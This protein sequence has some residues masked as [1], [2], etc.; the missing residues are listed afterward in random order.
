M[1]SDLFGSLGGLMKG[2]SGIMPQDD[3]KTQL[4]KLQSEVSDL[5]K[6]ENDLYAEIGRAAME[7]YGAE[8]FGETA[9]RLQLVQTDLAAARQKLSEAQAA[10][11]ERKRAEE[12][13]AAERRRA[14]L[15]AREERTCPKCGSENPEGTKFCQE[16][17][18]R[19]GQKNVCTSCG[20]ANALGVKFCQECGTRLQSEAAPAAC[21]DCGQE[22]PPGT[23][24]CGGCGT[25]LS[26]EN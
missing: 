10:E 23:R 25:K 12:A 21:P 20:T 7:Q 22:N 2:L 6:Q 14:E 5:Q 13:A 15:A 11:E 18:T 16:C 4:F 24:F 17:G 9:Q 3:P 19:L 26:A 8:G 1:A